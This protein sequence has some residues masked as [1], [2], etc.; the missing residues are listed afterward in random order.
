MSWATST[1]AMSMPPR[2]NIGTTVG[3]W[4]ARLDRGGGSRLHHLPQGLS[5][6]VS[7]RTTEEGHGGRITRLEWWRRAR[8]VPL[9]ARS[10]DP[11]CVLCGD[12]FAAIA[13]S[14]GRAEFPRG[15]LSLSILPHWAF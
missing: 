11:G 5:T 10:V 8:M 14:A 3:R 2:G 1:P 15:W 4:R 12:W 13:D 6:W 7:S 9:S